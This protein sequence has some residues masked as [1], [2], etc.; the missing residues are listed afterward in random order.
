MPTYRVSWKQYT[1]CWATVEADSEDE[2]IEK[3][4]RGQYNDDCDTDPGENIMKSYKC[5][6]LAP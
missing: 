1:H 5:D 6:G 4:K 3:A 2:A